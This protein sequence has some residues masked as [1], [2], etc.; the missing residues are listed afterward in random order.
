VVCTGYGTRL[1]NFLQ[2]GEKTYEAVVH[3]G[4][5]THT[6]DAEGGVT[7]EAPVPEDLAA[8]LDDALPAFRGAITQIPP[9]VSAI[10]VDGKRAHQLAREGA[11]SDEEMPPREVTIH[12]LEVLEAGDDTARLEVT[13]SPGTYIRT[14]AVD[15]GR[16]MGTAAHLESLRRTRTGGFDVADAVAL[17]ALL[18]LEDVGEHLRSIPDCLPQWPRRLVDGE[19][20]TRV[21]N[22][23]DVPYEDGTHD[24]PIFLVDPDGRALAVAEVEEG[25]EGARL[26][27]RRLL[28]DTT[29]GS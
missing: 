17:D 13:C 1:V 26:M 12:A 16:A 8:A 22:G 18:E 2:K 6:A 19:E 20:L 3:F 11:L 7:R 28:V 27:V 29:Q 23:G 25:E 21:L 9:A 10:R 15:L 5:E 24:G 14:L 4:A